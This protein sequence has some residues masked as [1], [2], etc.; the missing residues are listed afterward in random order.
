MGFGGLLVLK[1]DV[2]GADHLDAILLGKLQQHLV[3]L[4]LQG[5]GLAV[6]QYGG[7]L[8]LMALQLQIVVVAK[9]TVI[10]LAGLTGSFD[11][12]LDDL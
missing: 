1:V 4:L 11:I 12:A 8:H 10:P 9:H 5:V 6:G 3:G 2:V 7:I